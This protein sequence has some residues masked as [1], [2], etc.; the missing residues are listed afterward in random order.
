[1]FLL[2]IVDIH[3]VCVIHRCLTGVSRRLSEVLD[4]KGQVRVQQVKRAQAKRV[5]AKRAQPKRA[6]RFYACMIGECLFCPRQS[7]GRAAL[8]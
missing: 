4:M 3:T 8:R 2:D 6:R 5:Q 7:C 1:M